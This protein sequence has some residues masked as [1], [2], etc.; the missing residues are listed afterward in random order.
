MCVYGYSAAVAALWQEVA[1]EAGATGTASPCSGD[2]IASPHG[3]SDRCLNRL[4]FPA[5]ASPLRAA[6]A[7]LHP[8][9][10]VSGLVK[11]IPPPHTA[12]DGGS[13]L[14]RLHASP[15]TCLDAAALI[16]LLWA[17]HIPLAKGTQGQMC[18]VGSPS[19]CVSF[20]PDQQHKPIRCPVSSSPLSSWRQH[21]PGTTSHLLWQPGYSAP[22]C[23][24][25]VG[26]LGFMPAQM[27][28]PLLFCKPKPSGMCLIS[29][30]S[31]CAVLMGLLCFVTPEW[32][33][34]HK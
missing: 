9:G 32:F 6:S 5:L 23:Y 1:E 28:F 29:G 21:M 33:E 15:S 8:R 17:S 16:P 27:N 24:G 18:K 22:Q 10:H 11:E 20:L 26:A 31:F 14:D 2:V 4:W 13:C 12:G 19:F 7:A 3:S 34:D 25:R 30:P